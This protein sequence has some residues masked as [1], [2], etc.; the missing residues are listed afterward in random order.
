[1]KK[2]VLPF[3]IFLVQNESTAQ[4]RARP[5][6]EFCSR[7][8]FVHYFDSWPKL[9]ISSHHTSGGGGRAFP[10]NYYHH[11]YR[12]FFVLVIGCT[13]QDTPRVTLSSQW[14][15]HTTLRVIQSTHI[16]PSHT[17]QNRYYIAAADATVYTT[18]LFGPLPASSHLPPTR[19]Y[20]RS[21]PPRSRSSHWVQAGA[22]NLLLLYIIIFMF[23]II[24]PPACLVP[25]TDG[26]GLEF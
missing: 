14:H 8:C 15:I 3:A 5:T 1:M 10:T 2:F 16:T 11:H 22:W 6:L 20:V 26:V 25:C 13:W 7:L 18:S 17:Y 12:L 24:I 9:I 19:L 23:L 21:H 4:T